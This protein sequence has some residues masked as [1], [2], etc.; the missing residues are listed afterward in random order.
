[1][2]FLDLGVILVY[3]IAITWFGSRFRSGQKSL[4]DYFLGGRTAP[5]WAIAFSIVSAETSTLTVI[6]TPGIA[7]RGDLGFLQVVL[8]YLVDASALKTPLVGVEFDW[9]APQVEQLTSARL[10][11]GD[12]LKHW[13]TLATDAPLGSL[14]HGGQRLERKI[15]EYASHRAKYL[16]LSWTDAA[17]AIELKGVRGLSPEQTAQP[18]RAWKEIVA[19]P[20]AGK[21][22][23][24]LF[25]SGGRFPLDRFGL[26]LPQENTVVP[27]Q[28]FSRE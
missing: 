22:G 2:R 11:A 20:D 21:P 27:V 26:R 16:R 17:R 18:D 28:L 10:E 23:E 14:S 25:D 9:S 15:I 1:M 7:F 12:D 5:W 8:G 6:G 24:Y 3:L 13:T 19:T 4:K